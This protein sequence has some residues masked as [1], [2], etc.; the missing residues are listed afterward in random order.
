MPAYSCR[1]LYYTHMSASP[2]ILQKLLLICCLFVTATATLAEDNNEVEAQLEQIDQQIDSL[3]AGRVDNRD[4][5]AAYQQQI[6]DFDQQIAAISKRRHELSQQAKELQQALDQLSNQ[7]QE[8]VARIGKQQ[9]TLASHI[10]MSWLNRLNHGLLGD[11][12]NSNERLLKQIWLEYLGNQQQQALQALADENRELEKLQQQQQK[13]LNDFKKVSEAESIQRKTLD[14]K[15]SERQASIKTLNEEFDAAGVEISTLQQ[16]RDEL[17]EILKRLRA[18]RDDSAFL[19]NGTE[20]ESLKGQLPW[21]HSGQITGKASD[22]GVTIK[23]NNGDQ[24]TTIAAGRVAYAE[25]LK[26][27]GLLLIVDHGKGYMS[28]YGNN[29]TLYRKTGDWVAQGDVLSAAGQ[30][31]G[32]SAASLY[33]EIRA[34]GKSVDVRNWC[35]Q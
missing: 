6:Q 32:R 14:D 27:F 15:K 34:D 12:G 26:G 11:L 28:L 31:G 3:N 24:V 33:F 20:F 23:T 16:N 17:S 7:D 10:Q 35:K 19:E 25:W 13:A 22:P 9:Q 2:A 1:I 8:I 5:V 21:P 4:Q 29:E 18:A 30:S